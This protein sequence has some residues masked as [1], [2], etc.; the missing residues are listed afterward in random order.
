MNAIFY[1]ATIMICPGT[2]N[3]PSETEKLEKIVE[4]NPILKSLDKIRCPNCSIP[5]PLRTFHCKICD[6]Y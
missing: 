2:F 1:M 3:T 4:Q 6:K 5:I